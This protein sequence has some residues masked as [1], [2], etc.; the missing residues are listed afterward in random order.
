LTAA[1]ISP[2]MRAS[3]RRLISHLL[4]KSMGLS[5]NQHGKGSNGRKQ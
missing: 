1:F 4:I 3:Q 2:V 5:C